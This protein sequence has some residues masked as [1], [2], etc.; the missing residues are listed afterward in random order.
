MQAQQVG[1]ALVMVMLLMVVRDRPVLRDI[2]RI[3]KPSRNRH[4]RITLNNATS[5]TPS[6][7]A[8]A[9]GRTVFR[10]G[11]VFDANIPLNGPVFSANQ[12][13]VGGREWV[14]TSSPHAQQRAA[15]R[16]GF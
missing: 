5:I 16:Y 8:R 10:R 7:P 2:S 9:S 3:D 12:H 1:T 15:Y 14:T 13:P 4:R 11:P 6:S